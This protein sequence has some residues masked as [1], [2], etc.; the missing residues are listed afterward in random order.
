MSRYKGKKRH[1]ISSRPWKAH[2]ASLSFCSRQESQSTDCRVSFPVNFL[3]AGLTMLTVFRNHVTNIRRESRRSI[4]PYNG[5]RNGE[6]TISLW[7]TWKLNR[8]WFRPHSTKG[9]L[10]DLNSQLQHYGASLFRILAS[11]SRRN[12]RRVARFRP[13]RNLSASNYRNYPSRIFYW[14]CIITP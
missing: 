14:F 5:W 2:V 7:S 8:T 4:V 1:P 9:Y 11:K 12:S 6:Q 13:R 10:R 3:T